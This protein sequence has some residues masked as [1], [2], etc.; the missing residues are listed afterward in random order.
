M[1][2]VPFEL[3]RA[4]SAAQAAELLVQHEDEAKLL[5]GGQSLLPM[6][7]LRLATPSVLVDVSRVAEM[8][9]DSVSE[10]AVVLGGVTTHSD[11]EDGRVHDPT[12]GWLRHVAGGI[13]YRAIR[14]RGT[15]AGSLAHADGSAEWPVVMS[16]LDAQVVVRSTTGE[17]SVP[18]D[19]LFKGFFTTSLD[20]GEVI[21]AVRVPRQA[22]G[23][24][25]GFVKSTR[26]VGEFAESMCF[27]VHG[28]ERT[29][30][31]LGG[32][33]GVPRRLPQ[34]ESVL[35]QG[36]D[37]RSDRDRAG[38]VAAVRDELG[39]DASEN[40]ADYEGHLHGDTVWRTL[41]IAATTPHQNGGS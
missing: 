4:E 1:K 10:D 5:A 14:N 27:L 11:L 17:R 38:V 9:G 33:G 23:T 28:S 8:R 15:L 16:A 22:P 31:W 34:V 24:R 13:G 40:G 7:G 32:S 29:A 12:G 30:V 18:C 20:E 26:K 41:C 21:T 19:G 3:I 39:S 6:M 37:P 36:V 35:E 25:F 2:P